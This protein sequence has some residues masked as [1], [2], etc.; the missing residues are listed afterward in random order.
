MR[1]LFFCEYSR[2]NMFCICAFFLVAEV[3]YLYTIVD[4]V[5]EAVP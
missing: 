4:S 3:L 5:I 2:K 1:L